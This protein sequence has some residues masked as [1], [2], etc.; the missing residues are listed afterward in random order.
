MGTIRVKTTSRAPVEK[1]YEM[2]H[3]VY[4]FVDAL[5]NVR[6]IIV[7]DRSGDGRFMKTEWVL[8]V[9]LPAEYGRL[10]WTKDTHWDDTNRTC[11]LTLSPD[12]SGVVKTLQ[13]LWTF[14]AL[15]RG[16]EML[17]V[18]D[19]KV[20]HP[21]VSPIVQRIFDGLMRKNNEALLTAISRRAESLYRMAG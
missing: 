7:L 3:A 20:V 9:P 19:F 12:Y 13:G 8:N 15:E 10:S 1:L 18:M 5:P 4:D 14:R 11:R 21:M 16:T 17:L 6:D 2:A